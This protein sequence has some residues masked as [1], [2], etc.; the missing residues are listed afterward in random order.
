MRQGG[1]PDFNQMLARMPAST[2][3]DLNKGDAVIIVATEG[4]PTT[5]ST[6]ITLVSGVEPILRASPSA[7]QAM[8][9][10]PWSL[11]GPTGDAGNQ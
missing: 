8:M 9:L 6:A 3:A 4:S 10:A 11:S 7:G 2:V 1:A 5:T